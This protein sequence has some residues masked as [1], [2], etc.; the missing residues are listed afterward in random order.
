MFYKG[1]R[2]IGLASQEFSHIVLRHNSLVL[3]MRLLHTYHT[4][5]P[6]PKNH[7]IVEC[8]QHHFGIPTFFLTISPDD[9]NS[10]II[11]VWCGEQIDHNICFDSD[12]NLRQKV[13]ECIALRIEFPR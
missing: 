13:K 3:S 12:D 1:R 11:Q 9:E 7:N 8:L 5:M 10:W 4:L 2:R 6:L